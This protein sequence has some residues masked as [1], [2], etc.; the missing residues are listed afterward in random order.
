MSNS[1]VGTWQLVSDREAWRILQ[2]MELE[3]AA[4]FAKKMTEQVVN[5]IKTLSTVNYMYP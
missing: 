4:P 2:G 3:E 5:V 1:H